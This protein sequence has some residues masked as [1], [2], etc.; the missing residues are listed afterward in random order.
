MKTLKVLPVLAALSLT[1]GAGCNKTTSSPSTN[2]QL[3]QTANVSGGPSEESFQQVERLA[4]PAVN[5]GLVLT[6]ANLNL[7]NSLPPSADLTPAASGIIGEVVAVQTALINL[8]AGGP[9]VS[10]VAA[11]FLPDV[12]RIDLSKTVAPAVTAYNS[13]QGAPGK[14]LCGGRKI[15]DDVI[16]I[17]LS[18]LGASDPTGAA[19]QDGVAY[20]DH[21]HPVLAAFPYLAAPN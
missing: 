8:G 17:T 13:C 21:H 6:N 11:M 4:R 19:V 15:T 14:P 3:A 5:E 9:P 2:E 18:F 16:D 12:M 20:T 10:T 1:L 7:W